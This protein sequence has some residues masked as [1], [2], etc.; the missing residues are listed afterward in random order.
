VPLRRHKHCASTPAGRNQLR[1]EG[2]T[3][4]TRSVLAVPPG[5]DGL[6]RAAPC[7]FV[8]PRSRPW[9]SPSFRSRRRSAWGRPRGR[10]TL[11]SF[12]LSSSL[13]ASP[14]V[15]PRGCAVH[16]ESCP[17]AVVPGSRAA[18]VLP[19]GWF[20]GQALD[21]RALLRRRV[22]CERSVLPPLVARCSHGLIGLIRFGDRGRWPGSKLPGARRPRA[23]SAVTGRSRALGRGWRGPRVASSQPEG[24]DRAPRCAGLSP[25]MP[26]SGEPLVGGGPNKVRACRRPAASCGSVTTGRAV[27]PRVGG[28]GRSD[29]SIR[30]EWSLNVR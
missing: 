29:V 14:T 21:L 9:G 15:P 27:H 1:R 28:R 16:R 3:L 26:A 2:A 19:R 22:R 18:C 24:C 25:W 4:P 20:V 10:Y 6:L 17:P 30:S 8:A 23:K 5:Y 11:R 7:E 13:V 12:S